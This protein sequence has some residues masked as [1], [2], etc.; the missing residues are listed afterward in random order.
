MSE[1]D[2]LKDDAEKYAKDHPDQVHEGEQDAEKF[3]KSKFGGGG[4]QGQDGAQQNDQQGN[5]QGQQND[6]Q[7][8]TQGQQNDQQGNTQ[9]QQ[10][11]TQGQ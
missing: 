4:D 10:G 3:A 1:F 7:G 5:T 6:Q 8:N 2:Q 9:G 11:N